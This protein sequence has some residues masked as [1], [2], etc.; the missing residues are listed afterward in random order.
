MRTWISSLVLCSVLLPL[1]V[2]CTSSIGAKTVPRDQFSYAEALRDAWK[3]QML[4]NLVG[5][6]YAEAPMFLKVTSVINNYT[7][8]GGFAAATPGYDQAA[9]VNPPLEIVGKYA[10][11]PTISY[12]PLTGADFTRSVLTPIPPHSVMSLIQ[13]GWRVDLL[14]P[15][16]VRSVNGVAQGGVGATSVDQTRYFELVSLLTEIQRHDGLSFRVEQRGEDDVA[17]VRID[18]G[19]SDEEIELDRRIGEI[20]GLDPNAEEY[21]LV[22]GR[23]ASGPAEIAMLTRSIFEMLASL[24]QW[25]EVP[26]E[27]VASGRALPPPSA[28]AMERYGFQPLITVRSSLER[29]DDAFVAIRYDGRWF[30]IDHDDLASKRTL[31]FV[32]L[33]FSLAESSTSQRD[34]VVTVQ[35]GG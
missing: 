31:G 22:F 20:L 3:E 30:W 21:R 6:R 5:L 27:H 28:A 10:D 25:V 14:F 19:E 15:L 32:Q 8:E 29:P 9:V 16:T 13:A 23:E 18:V 7:F 2:G 26:P 4:L 11:R 1:A 17:I 12:T 34:P 24:A 35:A 33:M